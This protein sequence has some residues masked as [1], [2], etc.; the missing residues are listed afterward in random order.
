MVNGLSNNVTSFRGE[1]NELRSKTSV[2]V[3][4]NGIIKGR[5]DEAIS[6]TSTPTVLCEQQQVI[7]GPDPIQH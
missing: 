6:E 1:E 5:N 4:T 7:H 2:L 3:N